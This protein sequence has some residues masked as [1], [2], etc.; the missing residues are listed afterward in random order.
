MYDF[1]VGQHVKTH[2]FCLRVM[3]RGS[4]KWFWRNS[5]DVD[6]SKI[7][8]IDKHP[9]PL[10]HT[11]GTHHGINIRRRWPYFHFILFIPG[12]EIQDITTDIPLFALAELKIYT[13]RTFP[14]ISRNTKSSEW[15]EKKSIIIFVVLKMKI[16]LESKS[17]KVYIV[18]ITHLN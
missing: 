5:I 7:Q 2:A 6:R 10:E 17:Q 9:I 14:V 11:V 3:K 15:G 4:N 16:F 1:Y 12:P 13:L 18:F 8:V